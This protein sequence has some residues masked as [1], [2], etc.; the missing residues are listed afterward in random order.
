MFKT[1]KENISGEITEKKSKFI[2]SIFYIESVEEAEAK[3][4]EVEKKYY[5]SRH[6]CYAFSIYTENRNNK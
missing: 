6:N 1:I 4:K 2:A 3:I 5:N